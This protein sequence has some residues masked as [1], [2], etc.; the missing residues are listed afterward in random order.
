MKT[1]LVVV[2]KGNGRNSS[3]SPQNYEQPSSFSLKNFDQTSS[4][5]HQNYNPGVE[6]F[7]LKGYYLLTVVSIRKSVMEEKFVFMSH[8]F[9]LRISL[10]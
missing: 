10:E 7:E 4:F 6:G 1:K 8:F 3:I 9:N 2:V 5:S